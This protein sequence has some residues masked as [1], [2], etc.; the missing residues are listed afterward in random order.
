M[1]LVGLKKGS[2]L[3]KISKQV[4]VEHL[5]VLFQVLSGTKPQALAK[6]CSFGPKSIIGVGSISG[7]VKWMVFV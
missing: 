2:Y 4:P 1:F 6:A 7:L 3:V 5:V